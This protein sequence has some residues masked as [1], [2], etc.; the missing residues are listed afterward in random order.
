MKMHVLSGGRLR[1]KKAIYYP[2][3][4][5]E[6]TVD[7]PVSCILMRHAQGN[8]LFDTG[9][10]PTIA[11]NAEAR[12]GNLAKFMTPVMSP[13]DNVLSGLRA[14]GLGPD[15]I[16]VVICSHFHTDHCGCNEFFKKATMIV[17]A[18]ELSAAQASDSSNSG[19]FAADWK[20]ENPLKIIE[21]AED[22]FGDGRLTVIELPGHT[23]GTVGA[24]V[25][26]DRSGEFLLTSD[27]VSI[28][29]NLDTDHAPRNTWNVDQFLK[30]FAEVR[31]LEKAGASVI[32]G[33]DAAQWSALRKGM[34]AYD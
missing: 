27:A 25:K 31:K 21:S 15:G 24:L 32:C 26:L 20:T 28:R 22:V 18:R 13:D 23:P 1:M 4:G 5:R 19:Y 34:D 3:A 8:V 9:C 10:H 12:W 33:H 11:E 16:D 2:D 7:L 30:S 6:E 14:V 29:A 17:H